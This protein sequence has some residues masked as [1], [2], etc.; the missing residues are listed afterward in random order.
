[1][2]EKSMKG[3]SMSV[4]TAK[5]RSWFLLALVCFSGAG[6]FAL[7]LALPNEARAAA[8][9]TTAGPEKGKGGLVLALVDMQSA[10]LKTEDGRAAKVRIEKEAQSKR[11]ELLSQQEELNK[12]GQEF[13]AQ[14]SVLS[15]ASQMEKQREIQMKFQSLRSSEMNFEQEMRRKEM[16]E[17]HK[18]IQNLQKIIDEIAKMKGY[19]L[20]FERGAG[21]LLYAA[22]YKDITADVVEIYNSR[23]KRDGADKMAD[24]AKKKEKK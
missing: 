13:Q 21:A 7:G 12:M 9:E 17:T 18:I 22:D 16:E 3:V 11:A 6:A 4:C 8:E 24:A 23:H 1:M 14:Q 10:I 20:V 2:K 15:S 5:A 19:D